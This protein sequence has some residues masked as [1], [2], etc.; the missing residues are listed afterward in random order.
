MEAAVSGG[1]PHSPGNQRCNKVEFE[2]FV[3]EIQV[4]VIYSQTI[5]FKPLAYG[6][7][8]IPFSVIMAV[9]Y[10]FGVMSK[11]GLAAL[12]PVGARRMPAM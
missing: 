3:F 9:M 7:L 12:M 11:A 5:S 8:M 10:L 4:V 6:F 2:R 1:E